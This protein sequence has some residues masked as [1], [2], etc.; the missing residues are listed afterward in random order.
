MLINYKKLCHK[1]IKIAIT[2][3]VVEVISVEWDRKVT[4]TAQLARIDNTRSII[5]KNPKTSRIKRAKDK[6]TKR[7]RR[8]IIKLTIKKV[9]KFTKGF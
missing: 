6:A 8:P 7:Q 1:V 2:S 5:D 3:W 4:K 9:G